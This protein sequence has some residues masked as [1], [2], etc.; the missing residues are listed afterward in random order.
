MKLV[1]PGSTCEYQHT[2]RKKY[3]W[4][5][6]TSSSGPR[7]SHLIQRRLAGAF[8]DPFA[9]P[10]DGALLGDLATGYPCYCD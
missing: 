6:S 1:E 2:I 10:F 7:K 8:D 9:G 3:S 4:T 5:S